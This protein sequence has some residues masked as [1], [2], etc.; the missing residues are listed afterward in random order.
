MSR[1][2]SE[3]FIILAALA[4]MSTISLPHSPPKSNK[5]KQIKTAPDLQVISAPRRTMK[6]GQIK[7]RQ[8]PVGKPHRRR[9]FPAIVECRWPC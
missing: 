2:R 5:N 3:V 6:L 1:F 7:V 9:E 4:L 8:N